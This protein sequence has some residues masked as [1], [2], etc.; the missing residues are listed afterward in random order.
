LL[1]KH[2]AGRILQSSLRWA[3]LLS[4]EKFNP[5]SQ[6]GFLHVGVSIMAEVKLT[7]KQD[8]FC[9]LY[10]E[11]GNAS[12]AYRQSYDAEDMNEN[13]VSVKAHE[14]LNNGKI[15]VRL[16]QLRDE[17]MRRHDLTV[18]DLLRELEEARQ[19]AL[20]AENP[21]SSAAVAATMGKAKILGLDKQIV[22]Q[23]ING[24]LAHTITVV[25]DD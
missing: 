16:K 9:R 12:E 19:A 24:N 17:H 11:L 23:T 5:P 20:G 18:G 6:D 21:Q 4:G 15:T 13:V 3:F 25:F 22:E 1:Y 7:P 8:N 14:L 2:Y 10:I